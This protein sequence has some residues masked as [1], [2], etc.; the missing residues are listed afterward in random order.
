VSFDRPWALA[1]LFALPLLVWL[2]VRLQRRRARYAVRFTNLEVLA[3]LVPRRSWRRLVPAVL[4]LLALASLTT[5]VARPN[6]PGLVARDRA[7]V[8]LVLDVSGSMEAKDVKPSRLG[9]AQNAMRVFLDRAPRRLRV[10]LIV[11]AGFP[12]VAAPPTT[13]HELVLESLNSIG[14]YSSFGG[15]AIG[16]AI[17]EAV[18]LG[19][20]TLAS[21]PEAG[22]PAADTDKL[23]SILFLS[24]G[25]QRQGVLQPL[26]GAGRAK[27]AGIPVYT[28][29]LGTPN[30]TITRRFGGLFGGGP[31]TIPVPPDPDTLRLIAETTGGEFFNA[32]SADALHSAYAKLGSKLGRKRADKEITYVFLAAAAVLLVGAGLLSALWSPRLP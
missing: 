6:V 30:G 14:Q 9:A 10:G 3:P 19:R 28:I 11:F 23:V 13:K 17:A 31:R 5:A 21:D 8:V 22:G 27:A 4:V 15:T 26:E 7:T 16:D 12:Q 29:A 2:Y 32:T 25:A 18:S 1:A 20:Q 24:D